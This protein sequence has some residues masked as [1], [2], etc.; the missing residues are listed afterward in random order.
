MTQ[1]IL[2]LIYYNQKSIDNFIANKEII[3]FLKS[4]FSLDENKIV[5]IYSERGLGKT[6]L[7]QAYCNKV[8]DLGMQCAY[9]DCDN[10]KFSYNMLDTLIGYDWLFIDNIH[11]ADKLS[12][13]ILFSL[14]NYTKF[15]KLKLIIAANTAPNLLQL[16]LN[17][18]KTRL[19]LTTVFCLEKLTDN[20]KKKILIQDNKANNIVINES[21]Y[22]YLLKNYSRNLAELLILIVN[23]NKYS[24]QEHKPIS[25]F[26]LKKYLKST[27]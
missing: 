5:Y 13:Y 4:L 16:E 21:F 17:D 9:I 25:I 19:S 26:L 1:L 3:T 10:F 11:N 14:Y 6:H 22:D 15:S 24:M 20:Q 7:L 12:Q 23:I 8:I 2:P 27:A 18:L